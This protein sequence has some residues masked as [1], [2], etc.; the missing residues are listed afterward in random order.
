M[1]ATETEATNARCLG[2]DPLIKDGINEDSM[3]YLVL[4]LAYIKLSESSKSTFW[5]T[6]IFGQIA[7]ESSL[8][9]QLRMKVKDVGTNKELMNITSLCLPLKLRLLMLA[10]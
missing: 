10:V 7:Y 1:S 8:V 3:V 4:V 5:I 2:H 9:L 6:I